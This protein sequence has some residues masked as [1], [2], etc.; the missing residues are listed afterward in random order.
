ML[1]DKAMSEAREARGSRC[2]RD[3]DDSKGD[4]GFYILSLGFSHVLAAIVAENCDVC[5][6]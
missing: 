5:L 1:M 3:E 6:E 2:F 4:S